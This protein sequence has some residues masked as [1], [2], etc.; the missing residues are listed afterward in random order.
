M[1]KDITFVTLKESPHL[2][3]NF[4]NLC[5][6]VCEDNIFDDENDRDFLKQLMELEMSAGQ[7]EDAHN[8]PE[9]TQQVKPSIIDADMTWNYS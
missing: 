3:E 8:T 7:D 6:L 2:M 4:N 1:V 5:S 9:Y